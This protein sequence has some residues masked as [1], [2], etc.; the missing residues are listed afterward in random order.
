MTL[1]KDQRM[2]LWA[3][4]ASVALWA[5]APLRFFVLP[6]IFYN[7]HIHE[8]CHALTAVLTGGRVDY[9]LIDPS[10]SGVTLTHGGSPMLVSAAGYVGSSVVGGLLVYFSR[11][12]ESARK[13]LWVAAGF[14]A[15]SMVFFV[16]GE[17]IGVVT[18]LL[19]L[20][21]LAA[22]A[23][24]LRGNAAIFATQFLGVQ[25]C[26]TS[27]QALLIL[28][29]ITSNNLG[30]NDAT[31]MQ[32]FTHVPAVVWAVLWL[33]FSLFAVGLGIRASWSQRPR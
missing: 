11:T 19:W 16:R 17:T 27:A 10:G 14:L 9:I 31:N 25:Q 30:D 22:G 28:F 32:A 29:E 33:L 26:L 24:L 8:L 6:L 12:A 18:G 1:R 2:L 15:F 7:T 5:I 23:M 4:L 21:A 13:M 20:V 3:S